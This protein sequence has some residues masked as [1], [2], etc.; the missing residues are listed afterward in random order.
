MVYYAQRG[1]VVVR[2]KGGDPFIFGRGGEELLVLRNAGIDCEVIPGISSFYAVPEVAQIPLTFRGVSTAFGVF[3]GHEASRS[4]GIPW[5]AAAAMP[6]AVFLMGIK[7]LPEISRQLIANGRNPET[8]VAIIRNG[9]RSS[10]S[11]RISDLATAPHLEGLASPS[12]IVVGEVVHALRSEGANVH[13]DVSEASA[14]AK[15]L[16]RSLAIGSTENI[17]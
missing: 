10:Q 4:S 12:I 7:Q 16:F 13:D 14:A 9:T 5:R 6:T 1:N 2:L 8:P 17:A 15:D 11:V 3:T